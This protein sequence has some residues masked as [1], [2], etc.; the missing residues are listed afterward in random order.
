MT[1]QRGRK[2]AASLSTA[3]PPADFQA[4]KDRPPAPEGMTAVER[5]I[6]NRV[7]GAMPPGWFKREHIDLLKSFC[8]HAARADKFNRMASAF[9][10]SDVGEKIDLA[11]LDRISK[12]ADRESR[13]A[14]ALART[15]RITHQAQIR[16]ESAGLLR[17]KPGADDRRP[18]D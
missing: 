3:P 7:A 8:Q 11:D 17:D 1:K 16:P 10:S 12:M 9:E 18:W 13:A 2:S 15:M 5:I 14:L 4:A 6:W